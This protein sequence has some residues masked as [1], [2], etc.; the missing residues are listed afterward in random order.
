M[1]RF[2]RMTRLAVGGREYLEN[3]YGRLNMSDEKDLSAAEKRVA[4]RIQA[5]TQTLDRVSAERIALE[6]KATRTVSKRQ[7]TNLSRALLDGR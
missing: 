3:Q 7:R 5:A 2:L 4:E 1:R 6:T